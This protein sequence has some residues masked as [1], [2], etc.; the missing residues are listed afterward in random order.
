[1]DLLAQSYWA[2]ASLARRPAVFSLGL[3]GGGDALDGWNWTPDGEIHIEMYDTPGGYI[4]KD[5]HGIEL[6]PGYQIVGYEQ[7]CNITDTITMQNISTPEVDYDLDYIA[8]TALP[9]IDLK[10]MV[11]IEEAVEQVSFM[12]ISIRRSVEPGRCT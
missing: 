6:Q 9:D 3:Y 4:N 7:R 1:L 10:V 2:S 12:T 11:G 5:N 8:G